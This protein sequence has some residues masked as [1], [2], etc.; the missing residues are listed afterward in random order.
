MPTHQLCKYHPGRKE[1]MDITNER[2]ERVG[3]EEERKCRRV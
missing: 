1:S 3:R 2:K